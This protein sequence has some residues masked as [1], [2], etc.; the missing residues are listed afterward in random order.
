MVSNIKKEF[1]RCGFLRSPLSTTEIKSLAS[2]GFCDDDIFRIGCDMGAEQF[3]TLDE[4]AKWYSD[5]NKGV[6]LEAALRAEA[7]K[8]GANKKW[9]D[10]HLEIVVL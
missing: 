9:L 8:Q 4:A 10:D 5:Y 2:M 1:L 7:E 6:E 3:D